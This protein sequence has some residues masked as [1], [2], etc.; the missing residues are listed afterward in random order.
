MTSHD[1]GKPGGRNGDAASGGYGNTPPG[2]DGRYKRIALA[3]V[4]IGVMM[5]AI[6]TTAVILGLPIMM[7]QL[8]SSLMDMVWVIMAYLLVLTILGTQVGKLGD[9]Y[10]RIT[11]YLWGF[12]IFTAGSVFCGLAVGAPELI[13]FRVVQ[14]V[15]GALVFSNSGAIIADTFPENERGRAYGFVATGYSVG[16]V[17]GILLGGLIVNFAS[18]NYIFFINLPVGV[19]AM[20]ITHRVLREGFIL[21]KRTLDIVGALALG[22]GLFLVLFGITQVTSNGLGTEEASEMGGGAAMLAVFVIWERRSKAPLVSFS[23]F[24]HRILTASI[25]AAFLQPLAGFAVLFLVVMFLQGFRGMSPLEASLLLVPGYLLGGIVGI[26]GGRLADR[27]GARLVASLGIFF[28]S[29]GIFIYSYLSTDISTMVVVI[30]SVVSG[31][32]TG[33]FYPANNSAVMANAPREAYGLASGLLR[34]FANLGMMS[35]FA[36]A[37]LVSSLAISRKQSFA[38]FLGVGHLSSLAAPFERGMHDAFYSSI[39]IMGA[40]LVLSMLRGRE[41]R[42]TGNGGR[43]TGGLGS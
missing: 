42:R 14:A 21:T 17:A 43:E 26:F 18:W 37:F 1:D 13:A 28:Q 19:A 23:L 25:L 40:A 8:H 10:G 29:V 20:I 9:M 11:M 6:D 27:Y 22:L 39:A 33:L 24:R 3:V 5:T 16:A 35:S 38:I 15:G 34:T 32:G 30:G 7:K 4:L 2:G 31:I 12:G 36:I 41:E